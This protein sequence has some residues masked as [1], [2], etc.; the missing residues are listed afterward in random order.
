M[1]KRQII[2]TI[3][4]GEFCEN[5]KNLIDETEKTIEQLKKQ[6]IPNAGKT[7][8]VNKRGNSIQCYLRNKDDGQTEYI[9]KSN[10]L[11]AKY[12]QS[13]YVEKLVKILTEKQT[14]LSA[15][16]N[17]FNMTDLIDVFESATPG[18]RRLINPAFA[19]PEK[20]REMFDSEEYESRG[21]VSEEEGQRTA[22]GERVRSKSE[23]LIADELYRL[24]I[25][26]KYEYPFHF[27]NLTV[28]PDFTILNPNTGR[29]VIWEHFGLLDD[30]NYRDSMITK[31]RTYEKAGLKQG[32]NLFFTYETSRMTLN[33][34]DITRTI[35]QIM[36]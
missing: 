4:Y 35:N 12:A 36:Q 1:N 5:L 33:K 10:P 11:V 23:V 9:A 8:N 6:I 16:S 21:F 28:Y 24:G 14:Q 13:E 17:V 20:M 15:L 22:K 2:G 7:L 19:S 29:I 30:Q 3:T 25:S 27:G 18:R 32:R 26:Y 31:I 34:S